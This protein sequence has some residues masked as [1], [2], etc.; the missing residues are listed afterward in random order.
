MTVQELFKQVD[1]EDL[2]LAYLRR[3]NIIEYYDHTNTVQKEVQIYKI[4]KKKLFG[5]IDKMAT[6]EPNKVRDE[7]VFFIVTNAENYEDKQEK[8]F[9]VFSVKKDEYLEKVEKDFKIWNDSTGIR[10]EH[11]GIDFTE[12]DEVA[13]YEV[14]QKSINDYGLEVVGAAIANEMQAFCFGE[15][16]EAK[17]KM[18]DD[19]KQAIENSEKEDAVFYSADEVFANLKEDFYNH[20]TNKDEIAYFKAQDEFDEKVR[21]IKSNWISMQMNHNH[22]IL[23]QFLKDEYELRK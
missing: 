20:L 5:F 22:E 2:F 16:T 7:I 4:F 13:A 18:F 21:H 8:R 15:N 3:Y 1:K 19:I 9:H 17:Q 12:H 23:I 10:I 6:I 14:A 11:Y